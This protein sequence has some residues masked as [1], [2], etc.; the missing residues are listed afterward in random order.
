[1]YDIKLPKSY[2]TM[3]TSKLLLFF[4]TLSLFLFSCTKDEH[5]YS[6][7]NNGSNS[8]VFDNLIGNVRITIYNTENSYDITVVNGP[9]SVIGC[10]IRNYE[11]PSTIYF[12]DSYIY[13]GSTETQSSSSN[14]IP[15]NQKL[16]LKL[17]LYKSTV[18]SALYRTI[19]MLGLDFWDGINKYKENIGD[20]YSTIFMLE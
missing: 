2:M 17:V 13:K 14:G 1:M 6:L 10:A 19:E 15:R 7:S 3:K 12:S 16:E 5:I 4:L 8:Y 20:E 9:G 11:S 18:S